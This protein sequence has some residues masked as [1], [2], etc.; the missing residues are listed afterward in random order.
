MD[1]EGVIPP[2]R[3]RTQERDYDLEVYKERHLIECF[4]NKVKSYHRVF[5]R[6]EKRAQNYLGFV[7]FAS[8]LIWL[9]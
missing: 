2:P 1:A 6:F 5:S 4:F 8:S 9:R 3:N 7:Y